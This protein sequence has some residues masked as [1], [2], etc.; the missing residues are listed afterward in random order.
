[1]QWSRLVSCVAKH[2]E[3]LGADDH[4]VNLAKGRALQPESLE[5]FFSVSVRDYLSDGEVMKAFTTLIQASTPKVH[6]SHLNE[7]SFLTLISQPQ[8]IVS[9]K[10]SYIIPGSKRLPLQ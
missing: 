1:M 10:R 3:V 7:S 4:I 2:V 8:S 6:C 5:T 9:S